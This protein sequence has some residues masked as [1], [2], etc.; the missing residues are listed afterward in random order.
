MPLLLPVL[1]IILPLLGAV[2]VLGLS[3]VP[4]IRPYTHHIAL[5]AAG[6]TTILILTFTW[7]G[8]MTV[9]PSLWQP[10]L[11]FG[12]ALT[13]QTDVVMQPL[14][15]VL[16]LIT[17]S[18]LLVELGRTT[19]GPRPRLV[20]TLLA[21][22]S[23][24]LVVLWA[25]NL[26]TMIISWAIYDLLHA[27][28][29]IAAG[30]SGRTAIRGL[31]F[32]CLA[33]LVLWS[34]ALLSNGE[35]GSELWSLMALSGTPLTLW[36]VAGILRLWVYPLHLS[37][38]DDLDTAP[39]LAAPLLLGP[40]VGWGLWL[41]LAQVNGGSVPGSTWVPIVAAVTLAVGGFLAWSCESPRRMLPWI[42]MGVSG[43]V[44]LAAGLAGESTAAVIVAGGVAWALG[45][46][47]LFMSESL[48]R[49]VLWWNIP[50]LVGALA[51]VGVPLTLGFVVEAV[52]MGGL[53]DGG[54]L[55]LGGAFFVGH[56]FLVP[57]LVRWL[58]LS[59]SSPFPRREGGQGVKSVA[60]GVGLG[61][62]A[63]LLIVAG[64]HPPLLIGGVQNPS[65]GR[66]FVMP[67]LRG[68][69]LWTVSLV[70]GGVLAW[71]EG[72]LRP[73]IELFLSAAHDLLRL[74]WLY[75]AVAG[76]LG[77]GLCMLRAADEVV[78][79]AGALL[80]SWLLFLLLLLVWGGK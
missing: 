70:G 30:G 65:L 72:N 15:L 68:W 17:C 36:A 22:L 76:A 29:H 10:S 21:L 26:L 50:P 24:G 49:E 74:E 53:A 39:S 32:G 56:L 42:G 79:G 43:A 38:P 37:T 14:A 41:R 61:L 13:L 9:V 3:L 57:S 47:V 52:L 62:P 27:A 75:S 28:G 20:A 35:A 54:S 23:V 1:T 58:L 59:P 11:L 31:V 25:A 64:L 33:T 19:E 73:K 60:R 63:L 4:R 48:Q 45:I 16:A 8:P 51:L 40:I 2:G 46:A 6:L 5:T 12:A 67:G 55:G 69:L 34:G 77:R 44:L 66:L 80:W 71:Q 7:M 78:G 18:A